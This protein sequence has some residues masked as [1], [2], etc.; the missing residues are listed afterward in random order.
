MKMQQRIWTVIFLVALFIFGI[1]NVTEYGRPIDE[2]VET[3]F[4]LMNIIEYSKVFGFEL[5]S[6]VFANLTR[7]SES[8]DM[9]HGNAVY[10]PIVPIICQTGLDTI[11]SMY[12][13]HVYTYLVWFLGVL[14]LFRLLN[15]LYHNFWTPYIGTC[16]YYFLP[17]IYA[18]SHYNNK[19][20][21]FLS[22]IIIMLSFAVR[23]LK[24]WKGKDIAGFAIA[25]GFLMNC[26]FIGIVIWGFTGLFGIWYTTRYS[27]K[28]NRS[29]LY[30]SAVMACLV[31]FIITPAM[32]RFP[33][34]IEFAGVNESS[35]I[36]YK[37]SSHDKRPKGQ[38][39]KQTLL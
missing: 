19:D 8:P 35:L 11:D 1:S 39:L 4:V 13:W 6:P 15:E 5:K 28:E 33:V 20:I 21:I 30:I 38:P 22:I 9:D 16:I 31:F 17:R 7:I 3:R 37:H 27:K 34:A 29:N 2:P 12:V 14:F 36:T 18:E 23:A 10:Y 32:W 24:T 26:R 25:S